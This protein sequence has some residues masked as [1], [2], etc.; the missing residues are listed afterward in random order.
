MKQWWNCVWIRVNKWVV[1]KMWKHD[2][3]NE[4]ND[5]VYGSECECESFNKIL[6]QSERKTSVM[7]WNL[8]TELMNKSSKTYLMEVCHKTT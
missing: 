1:L 7:E 5:C 4:M 8:L 6:L 2:C 3:G